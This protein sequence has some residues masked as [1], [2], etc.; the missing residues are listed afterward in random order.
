[1]KARLLVHVF[2]DGCLIHQEF[3][4]VEFGSFVELD[5]AIQI[6]WRRVDTTT[7]G[8]KSPGAILFNIWHDALRGCSGGSNNLDL[9][10]RVMQIIVV[11]Y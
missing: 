6:K 9:E 5:Q 1:M 7:H 11:G 3:P 4:E 2:Q 8:P 10:L